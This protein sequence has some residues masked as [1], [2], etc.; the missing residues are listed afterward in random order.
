MRRG[1]P[2]RLAAGS[3]VALAAA[4]AVGLG[5][6]GPPKYYPVRGK[7]IIFGVGPLS[8]GE[9]RFRSSSGLVATGKI[10][11]DGSFSL[12]TPEHGEGLPLGT[13]RAAVI[14]APG[15][16]KRTFDERY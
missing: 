8:E 10:Q 7:V 6:C 4:L 5:G 13:Y 3:W 12:S 1:C 16:G 15:K 11:K 9:V 14:A 2:T